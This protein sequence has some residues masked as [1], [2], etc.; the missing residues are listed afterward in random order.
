MFKLHG[1]LNVWKSSGN[2]NPGFPF[3]HNCTNN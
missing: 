1:A 2:R 3:K